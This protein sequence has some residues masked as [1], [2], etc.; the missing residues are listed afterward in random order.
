VKDSEIYYVDATKISQLATTVDGLVQLNDAVRL[1]FEIGA[2]SYL[3]QYYNDGLK[4]DIKPGVENLSTYKRNWDELLMAELTF[5]NFPVRLQGYRIG[6][7]YVNFASS[8]QNTSVEKT[9]STGEQTMSNTSCFAGLIPQIG[10]T[11]NNRQGLNAFFVKTF[12]DVKT[13]LGYG[14]SQELTNYAGDVRNGTRVSEFAS[15]PDSATIASYTNSIT[16]QHSLNKLARSRFGFWET[17]T[18]PY[19]RIH[20]KYRQSYENIVITDTLVDYKKSYASV[21]LEL[22][23]KTILFNR[24]VIFTNYIQYNSV[25]ENISLIPKFDDEAFIRLL[26]NEF[27]VFYNIRHN[28][29]LVGLLGYESVKGNSRTELADENGD[30]IMDENGAIV[31]DESG[32]PINQIDYGYGFG[33]DYTFAD[34]ASLHYRHRWYSHEDIHFLSDTFKGNEATIELKIFF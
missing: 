3:S 23:Y 31:F 29:T 22:K 1:N 28:V 17:N 11:T 2:G 34:R 19:S 33:I 27:T 5:A 30:L 21:E 32:N 4:E 16:F 18:G 24:P 8:I 20:N 25:Q 10:Q 26:Y 12:G 15:E 14:I 6:E 7:Q 9:G 13:H